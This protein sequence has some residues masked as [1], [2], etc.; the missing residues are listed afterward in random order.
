TR[1]PT[2]AK[3]PIPTPTS[4]RSPST[5]CRRTR[6]MSAP[7]GRSAAASRSAP[8]NGVPER[9]ERPRARRSAMPVV[10]AD[11]IPTRYEL[12]GQGPALLMFSPGGFDSSLENWTAFGRYRDLGFV[13]AFAPWYTCVLFDRRES[14]QSGGRVQRL[15]WQHYVAQAVALID[16]L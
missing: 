4:P 16:H 10:D 14:G 6:T 8:R 2:S 13:S 1:R 9:P 7:A 15:S 3:T 11:G 5:R 12:V